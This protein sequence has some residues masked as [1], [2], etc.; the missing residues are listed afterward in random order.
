MPVGY[1]DSPSPVSCAEAGLP[2]VTALVAH[3]GLA[4]S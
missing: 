1:I 4:P 2:D 3:M